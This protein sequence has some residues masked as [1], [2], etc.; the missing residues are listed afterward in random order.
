MARCLK[1]N[2]E[3]S[4]KVSNPLECP[5]CRQRG[6]DRPRVFTKRNLVYNNPKENSTEQVEP[7]EIK[8]EEPIKRKVVKL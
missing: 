4:P 8:S 7:T 1:C 5:A 2:H 3:W 6:W